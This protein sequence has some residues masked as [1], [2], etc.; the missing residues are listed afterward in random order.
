MS[1]PDHA[2]LFSL[3]LFTGFTGAMMPGPMFAA[4]VRESV[5]LGASAG[6]RVVC[7]HAAVEVLVVVALAAGLGSYLADPAWLRWISGLGGAML[8]VFGWLTLRDARAAAAAIGSARAGEGV[9]THPFWAGLVTTV[10]NPYFYLW[11]SS[12]GL[13]LGTEAAA[14]GRAGYAT[15]FAGHILADFTWYTLVSFTLARG[16]S[17]GSPRV[18]AGVLAL[19]GIALIG[20]GG[21]FLSGL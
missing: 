12:I 8:I 1:L 11:W 2:A 7:G 3:A 16:R 21:W 18:L 10:G 19:C 5:R 13:K 20:L 6:P 4:T 9:K 14:L 17:L 15:F